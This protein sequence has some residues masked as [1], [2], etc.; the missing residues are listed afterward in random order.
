MR[1]NIL[2]I[3]LM[4]FCVCSHSFAQTA[5]PGGVAPGSPQCGPS[6]SNHGG[7]PRQ[8]RP[9]PE[10]RWITTWGA[11]ALDSNT[12][13]VGTA[14]GQLSSQEADARALEICARNGARHCKV[15]LTYKNQC[16]AI[17][18]PNAEG[19][20]QVQGILQRAPT[21]ELARQSALD[22]CNTREVTCRIV[23]EECTKPI[24]EKF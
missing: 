14:V 11:I 19:G 10:G 20:G 12:G 23:Y 5:C 18:W 4:T 13:D 17:A 3:V 9:V 2:I 1:L 21:P 16:A 15:G 24:F 8:S 7:A 6:P 22:G